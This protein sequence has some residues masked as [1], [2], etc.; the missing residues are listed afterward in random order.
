MENIVRSEGKSWTTLRCQQMQQAGAL[1]TVPEIY[2]RWASS[3]GI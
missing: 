3:R 2:K 1:N